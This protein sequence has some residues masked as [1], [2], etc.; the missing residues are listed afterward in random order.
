MV[1]DQGLL[2]GLWVGVKGVSCGL[3]VVVTCNVLECLW[4]LFHSL[5]QIMLWKLSS[6]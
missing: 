1:K 4:Q 2:L 3:W 6:C 5:V